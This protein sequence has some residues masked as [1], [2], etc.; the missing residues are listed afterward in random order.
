MDDLSLDEALAELV[1]AEDFLD[2]FGVPYRREV[3]EV[4]RLHI[5]Q[6]WHDY[7]NRLP[8]PLPADATARRAI[9]RDWLARAYDDFVR[10]DALTEKVFAVFRNVPNAQGGMTSFVPIER[11]FR[12]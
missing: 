6:R 3:V 7:L 2:Y 8:Q 12:S 5:L 1:S 9:Y 10:S 4:N 11:V